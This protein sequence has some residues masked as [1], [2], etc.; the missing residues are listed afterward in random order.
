LH[1]ALTA[2]IEVEQVADR[3][4]LPNNKTHAL[5]IPWLTQ[6]LY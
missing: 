4:E 3:R 1:T 5:L 6:K 2:D